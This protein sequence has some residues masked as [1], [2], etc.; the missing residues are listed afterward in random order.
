MDKIQIYEELERRGELG[1]LAPE[2]RVLWEEYKRRQGVAL[3]PWEE[4]QNH[5]MQPATN[6]TA[7][8]VLGAVTKFDNGYTFGF[9]RKLGGLLNAVGSWPV[10]RV[11]QLLGSPNTPSFT[12]RY[13]EITNTAGN[14]AQN[15]SERKPLSAIGLE[16][17]GALLSPINKAGARYMGN[18]GTFGNKL[19][20]AGT[21]GAGTST[22]YS[23]GQADDIQDFKDNAGWDTLIGTG[24]NMAF[25]VAGVGV[26]GIGKL[27]GSGLGLTTGTGNAIG[28]AA[29]AGYRGSKTFLKNMRGNKP[30]TSV[31]DEAKEFFR[32]LKDRQ[33]NA[34]KAGKGSIN[35]QPVKFLPIRNSFNDL[36]NEN[37][38][39][40]TD[41]APEGVRKVLNHA[42]PIL[43]KYESNSKLHTVAGI[44][45]L[46]QELGGIN[47]APNDANAL[48]VRTRLYN[49]A[50][51]AISKQ[52]PEY[53]KV[54]NNYKNAADQLD[55]FEK[56]LGL[57]WRKSPAQTLKKLQGAFRNN[58]TSGYGNNTSLIRQLEGESRKLTDALAGQ[59]LSDFRPRG[60]SGNLSALGSAA[61]Y[62]VNPWSLLGT[63]AT[64]PRLIGELAYGTGRAARLMNG[65]INPA[66]LYFNTPI[67]KD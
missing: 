43:K 48:R 36:V 10:D 21:V 42:K 39:A 45:K 57:G 54:M 29:N 1:R 20:R 34:Y 62:L 33:L 47:I 24:I 50:K 13:N 58:A 16:L 49:S 53:N 32:N 65:K 9:G 23:A 40:G 61:G 11:A 5:A 3:K 17:G 19:L 27:I 66:V 30:M 35:D 4:Y 60:L 41:V 44:D 14:A 15:F 26:R 38:L 56:I 64:S 8:D 12:D 37:I 59:A 46:K 31:V 6:N 25:P 18:A 28:A 63:L 52:S 2:K 67:E 55:E 7:E 22:L 51:D